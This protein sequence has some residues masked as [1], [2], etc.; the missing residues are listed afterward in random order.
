[1]FIKRSTYPLELFADA[2][3][4]AAAATKHVNNDG[5]KTTTP[6]ERTYSRSSVFTAYNFIECLLVELTQA[7]LADDENEV[8]EGVRVEIEVALREAK[9]KLSETIKTWPALLG[10]E[11]VHGK[12]EFGSFQKLRRLRNNLTHPKLQPLGPNELTQDELLQ[13][14]NAD[15]AAW[16][17]TEV[18]K[19]GRVL[20]TAFGVDVPPEVGG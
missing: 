13:E 20:Y 4:L 1:M 10:K 3:R 16:A 18:K 15:N 5:N 2:D 17:V 9:A 8:A 19:M 12:S 11:P 14:A 6:E 7:H